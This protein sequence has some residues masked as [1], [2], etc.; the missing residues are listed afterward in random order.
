MPCKKQRASSLSI[1]TKTAV[2]PGCPGILAHCKALRGLRKRSI[3]AEIFRADCRA[4]KHFQ[5]SCSISISLSASL[6]L[7][8]SSVTLEQCLVAADVEQPWSW[9]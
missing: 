8:F 7:C 2:H 6:F 3:V 5:L 9:L 4:G 1:C